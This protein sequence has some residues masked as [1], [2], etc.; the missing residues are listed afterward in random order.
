MSTAEIR[1]Q[2]GWVPRVLARWAGGALIAIGV[3]YVWLLFSLTHHPC[4]N[5]AQRTP[6]RIGRPPGP[7]GYHDARFFALLGLSAVAVLIVMGL[8]IAISRRVHRGA[9]S[10]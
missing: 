7:C 8:S 10:P 5:P 2:F 9:R 6:T 3:L 1:R 4:G